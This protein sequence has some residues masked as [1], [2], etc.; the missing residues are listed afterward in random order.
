MVYSA[1]AALSPIDAVRAGAV[2]LDTLKL[3][4]QKATVSG[5]EYKG[6]HV[7]CQGRAAISGIGGVR[8]ELQ[9]VKITYTVQGSSIKM[10]V[11]LGALDRTAGTALAIINRAAAEAQLIQQ[12]TQNKASTA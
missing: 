2:Q 8:M 1:A 10:D 9:K 5:I 4:I 3:P 12:N 7:K 11:Q 6:K